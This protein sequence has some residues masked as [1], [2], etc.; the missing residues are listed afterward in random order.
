M[1]AARTFILAIVFF[2]ASLSGAFAA[3][4]AW[5]IAQSDGAVRVA[6]S[7]AGM[8]PASLNAVLRPGDIIT[9]GGDGYVVLRRGEQQIVVSANSRMSLPAEEQ[10]GFT[11]VVQEL[12]TLMFKVDKRQVQHFEVNTP[13]VAAVV[14]GTTFTVTSGAMG[15]SVHVAEGL[16]E[17]RT[18]AGNAVA[19]VPGGSTVF[20]SKNRPDVITFERAQGAPT[21]D[22]GATKLEKA[23]IGGGA[24]YASLDDRLVIPAAIGAEPLDFAGLT[25][26]LVSAGAKPAPVAPGG[27]VGTVV[28]SLNSGGGLT[29][30]ASIGGGGVSAGVGADLGGGAVTAG[31]DVGLGGGGVTAGVD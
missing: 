3:G 5:T 15:D 20:V 29:T 28:A 21:Q 25:D 18:H 27:I 13:I 11:R 9:T 17:V 12:G 8:Q 30:G 6:S 31:V 2:F 26:G 4:G 23:D 1:Q 14:K 10:G 19:N 16:V 7:G 24:Q 22:G